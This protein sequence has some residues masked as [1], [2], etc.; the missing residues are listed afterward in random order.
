MFVCLFS[1]E[2]TTHHC[3]V[4]SACNR[5]TRKVL[6]REQAELE[7]LCAGLPGTPSHHVTS[8]LP[9]LAETSDSIS[10]ASATGLFV[11]CK[12]LLPILSKGH[13]T[14]HQL[15]TQQQG[16]RRTAV[17]ASSKLRWKAV[18]F[19]WEWVQKVL[20]EVEAQ[21]WGETR[22]RAITSCF[23]SAAYRAI[24]LSCLI[25]S[26]KHHWKHLSAWKLY[27]YLVLCPSVTSYQNT[28]FQTL[29]IW[30]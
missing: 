6:K 24:L 3:Q 29:H 9:E 27:I 11:S 10:A 23:N 5:S 30:L 8:Y 21:F 20:L 28:D 14:P 4:F 13:F 18:W 12:A 15:R 17:T 26:K 2:L 7:Q 16:F 19:R 25:Q 1:P 22:V